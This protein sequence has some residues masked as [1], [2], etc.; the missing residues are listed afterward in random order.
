MKHEKKPL[1]SIITVCYNEE[2]TIKKT[3][4]SVCNQIFRDF[5]WIVVDGKST[6]KTV[7]IIDRYKTDILISEDNDG[8]YDAMNKGIKKSRGKYLLFLNGGDYLMNKNVLQEV[9]ILIKQD[10]K[11]NDI[12]YGDLEYGNGD[13]VTFV[14]S[15]LDKKFFI[16]KTISHQATF[17]KKR[18]FEEYG[19]YDEKYK[20]SADFDFWIKTIIVG[21][22]KT[23]YL[24]V[25]VSV[26][27]LKGISTNSK[28]AKKQINERNS[29]LLSYNLINKYQVGLARMKSTLL[30][31]LKRLGLYNYIRRIYRSVVKR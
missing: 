27:D 29:I 15:I 24:P 2:K 31:V 12:Y 7:E 20:I 25:I 16:T 30:M 13:I 18:L 22:V 14:K 21:N 3:C 11:S 17:I 8:V 4:D 5:E 1:L 9:S 6:D 23:K 10:N 19:R 28:L 26:F